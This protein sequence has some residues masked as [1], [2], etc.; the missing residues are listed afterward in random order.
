MILSKC[1][2]PCVCT[3]ICSLKIIFNSPPPNQDSRGLSLSFTG[4]H[5][6]APNLCSQTTP[7]VRVSAPQLGQGSCLGIWGHAVHILCF[8]LVISLSK[9]APTCARVEFFWLFLNARRLR[10]T[11]GEKAC[12]VMLAHPRR[13]QRETRIRQKCE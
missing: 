7:Y 13:L 4:T 5:G 10:E 9:V 8:L 1:R 12:W 6:V 3:L 2:Q 11:Y